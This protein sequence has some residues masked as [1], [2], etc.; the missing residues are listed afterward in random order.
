MVIP[1]VASQNAVR[2]RL[3]NRNQLSS[4]GSLKKIEDTSSLIYWRKVTL[5][6][7]VFRPLNCVVCFLPLVSSLHLPLLLLHTF[8]TNMIFSNCQSFQPFNLSICANIFPTSDAIASKV[9]GLPVP[10]CHRHNK[11]PPSFQQARI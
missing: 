9:G 10:V 3:P 7:L 11:L 8:P 5:S 2:P 1:T 6:T 4:G